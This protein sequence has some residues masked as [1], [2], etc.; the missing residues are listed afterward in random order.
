M[1]NTVE[2]N[3]ERIDTIKALTEKDKEAYQVIRKANA[4]G[5]SNN[6]LVA[7]INLNNAKKNIKEDVDLAVEKG[8]LQKS[9]IEDTEKMKTLTTEVA[10]KEVVL[11]EQTT[12]YEALKADKT[13]VENHLRETKIG[14]ET[15]KQSLVNYSGDLQSAVNELIYTG[16][17]KFQWP[18]D[19]FN[20]IT[21]PYGSRWGTNH[22]GVDIGTMNSNPSVLAA[23]DGIVVAAED[24]GD[25]FG[26][27]VIINHGSKLV[28]LYGHLDSLKVSVGQYVF[29]GDIIGTAGN[30]GANF[31][32]HLHFQVSATNQ[33]YT[34]TL[35]PVG[36]YL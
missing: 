18:V 33:I 5:L 13:A 17:G 32:N 8:V 7:D 1:K 16:S 21:S 31:G 9:I 34:D 6:P 15:S 4:D 3:T 29:K 30:T 22:Q 10:E 14:H 2:V 11:K 12:A 20:T 36:T 23:D 26:N 25:G 24:N 28:T 19:G 35:D 27:K